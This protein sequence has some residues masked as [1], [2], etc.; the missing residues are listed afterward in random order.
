MKS[1]SGYAST[2]TETSIPGSTFPM[3]VSST[4]ATTSAVSRFASSSREVPPPINEVAEEMTVPTSMYSSRMMPSAGARTSVSLSAIREFS[5]SLWALTTA[6]LALSF[7][8]F[9]V[10]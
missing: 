4:F 2:A 8:S 7:A 6:A 10:S 1:W 9:A 5:R 3:S